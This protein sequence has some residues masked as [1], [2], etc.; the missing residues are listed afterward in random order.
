MSKADI[1]LEVRLNHV[2]TDTESRQAY[3]IVY[4]EGDISQSHSF[5]LWTLDLL[6]LKS[7]ESYLDVSCGL[8]ELIAL[9]Q[10]KD[11]KTF[12]LDIS[13]NALKAGQEKIGS[14]YL[15]TANSQD[16][17][18]AD[19]SFDV[20]S[21]IGS[22]EH[23]VDMKTA[24]REMARV[25]KPDGRAVILVP[26]TFSLL[27]NVWIAFRKGRTS[28]DP[29]QPIQRYAARYEWQDLLQENGLTV[30]KTIKYEREWPRT[31]HDFMNYVR[32]P[33]QIIRLLLTP[34]VPLNMAWSFVFICRRT[35]V[36]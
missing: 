9:A 34:F 33:K 21:N 30:E 20:I 3:D 22:L 5:Y 13:H 8:G 26:N 29:Y 11:V 35:S 31:K 2:E 24:V 25:L 6:N 17:P 18:Y 14:K 15:T 19:N 32:H 12:G 28:I 27:I 23:F 16:L 10:E 36:D 7:G 4:D 1:M